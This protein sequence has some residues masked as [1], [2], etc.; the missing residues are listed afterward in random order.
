METKP[1]IGQLVTLNDEGIEQINGLRSRDAI[2]QSLKM[3]IT[4][5]EYIETSDSDIY[6]IEVD[7]P[8]INEYMI[9]NHDVDE[10]K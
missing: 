7:Q 10:I 8:L 9:T 4:T 1:Y 3:K 6:L 5:I 2:K